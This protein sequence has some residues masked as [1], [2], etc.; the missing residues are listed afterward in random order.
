MTGIEWLDD[1]TFPWEAVP[2]E[3]DLLISDMLHQ[4]QLLTKEVL[5]LRYL[6]DGELL[7][8][9]NVDMRK[10][11]VK[12]LQGG[13][14]ERP[15]YT[16]IINDHCSGVDVLDIGPFVSDLKSRYKEKQQLEAISRMF[17]NR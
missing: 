11:S 1:V 9:D 17:E 7:R 14:R 2:E 3:D 10:E 12:Q 8:W 5:W 4:I 6:S 16:D 13:L 15:E